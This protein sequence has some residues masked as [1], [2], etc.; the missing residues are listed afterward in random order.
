MRIVEMALEWNKLKFMEV[1]AACALVSV[2]SGCVYLAD[3]VHDFQDA[4][5]LSGGFRGGLGIHA[6]ATGLLHPSLGFVSNGTRIGWDDRRMGFAAWKENERFFP[7]SLF[8][9]KNDPRRPQ[10]GR[11]GMLPVFYVRRSDWMG[12]KKPENQYRIES[13]SYLLWSEPPAA[14]FREME[15]TWLGAAT[16]GDFEVGVSAFIISARVGVN[17]FETIDLVL[18]V[19]T[20]DLAEDDTIVGEYIVE[21]ESPAPVRDDWRAPTQP[22]PEAPRPVTPKKEVPPLAA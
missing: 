11:R 17:I 19:F 3:R 20:I 21:T 13:Y 12:G 9:V 1:V 22:S 8:G 7:V 4:I 14:R 6:K 16:V 2:L 10:G 5:R 18:G 15:P